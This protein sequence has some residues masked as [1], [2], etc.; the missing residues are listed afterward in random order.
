[1]SE[2]ITFEVRLTMRSDWHIGDKLGAYDA[3]DSRVLRDAKNCP[4]IPATSLRAMLRDGAEQLAAALNGEEDW[5]QL[6]IALFG[7][8]PAIDPSLAP[9]NA[10]LRLTDATLPDAIR[11]ATDL[12]NALTFVKPGV[13]IDQRN[14][15]AK[16]QHL[17]MDE[18]SRRN[19]ILKSTATLDCPAK[20]QNV[21]IAFLT[22][23][24]ALTQR[25]GGK[26][27]RGLGKTHIEV[28]G[29]EGW[30]TAAWAAE[31][32]QIAKAPQIP[33]LTAGPVESGLFS[34]ANQSRF[35]E[36]DIEITLNEQALLAEQVQGNIIVSSDK[37]P[38]QMLLGALI[39]PLQ[40]I[41]GK[42]LGTAITSGD[43]RVSP[44]HPQMEGNRVLPPPLCWAEDKQSGTI[45]SVLDTASN[46]KG[47]RPI[48]SGWFSMTK[49]GPVRMG[50]VPRQITTHNSVDDA[51]QRPTQRAGGGVYVYECLPRGLIFRA[52]L[53]ARGPTAKLLLKDASKLNGSV[54][55]G[56]ATVGGYGEAK[57][58][59]RSQVETRSVPISAAK[60][61]IYCESDI[62]VRGVG[63]K[64]SAMARDL[65]AELN[66]TLSA[67]GLETT[68]SIDA[69][70]LG[71]ARISGWRRA[72]GAHGA[73]APE[74]I[75]IKA[76]SVLR[77]TVDPPPTENLLD[78][79]QEGGLGERRAEGFGRIQVNPVFLT[80]PVKNSKVHNTCDYIGAK[81]AILAESDRPFAKD[82]SRAA[83]LNWITLAAE[84]FASS[85]D[86]K[87]I[88]QVLGFRTSGEPVQIPSMNQL[89][90][91]RSLWAQAQRNVGRF[92]ELLRTFAE[93][94]SRA[95]K[96]PERGLDML[97]TTTS[98]INLLWRAL[99]KASPNAPA[100]IGMSQTQLRKEMA[101]DA[102]EATLHSAIRIT[103]RNLE[104]SEAEKV[105]AE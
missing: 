17:R 74:A 3:L 48:R 63:G 7:G 23:A 87:E 92:N 10:R 38:G 20:D 72:W 57:L 47:L 102:L 84:R 60:L 41:V 52:V 95:E 2:T 1:M 105:G 6:V 65:A 104:N 79:L 11:Q 28:S 42:E 45:I 88:H 43:I 30:R 39:K 49:T 85:T 73:P 71:S 61:D 78:A 36:F 67:L 54:R 86:Q 44:A 81:H 93:N 59:V 100:P 89:G 101:S 66:C 103:K 29:P 90:S 98:D 51:L 32:L 97:K 8:Q 24:A 56:R 22:A 77:V 33:P 16:E 35:S 69:A 25:I 40:K 31:T 58:D 9:V 5:S 26:R 55:I 19:A 83:T 76:G 68:L 91:L 34:A 62:I 4:L 75:A 99:D 53:S 18:V 70:Y 82:I 64:T 21:V 14:G 12:T 27:R 15:T 80:A 46:A 37:I 50:E 96:W 94:P 13:E